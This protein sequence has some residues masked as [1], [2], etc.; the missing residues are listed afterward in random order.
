MTPEKVK[1]KDGATVTPG[2][3]ITTPTIQVV[4][5]RQESCILKP[6]EATN[7]Q[8]INLISASIFDNVMGEF[9]G[10]IAGTIQMERKNVLN[11]LLSKYVKNEALYE[12]KQTGHNK[13]VVYKG[14]LTS[15]Q[16]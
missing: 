5:R 8:L 6:Y 11:Y 14:E 13:T 4:L 9:R 15:L 10:V 7:G 3:K 12:A 16:R 1:F 2:V